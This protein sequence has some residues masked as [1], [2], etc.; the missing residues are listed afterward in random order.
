MSHA[1][2][3][4][5]A[6][7]PQGQRKLIWIA[8]RCVALFNID[9]AVYA[10]DNACPHQGAALANGSLEGTWLRCPAHGLRFNL[11][12]PATGLC[13]THVPISIANDTLTVTL[14]GPPNS[15]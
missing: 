3:I 14:G 12:A 10:I 8:D 6:E 15:A 13:L 9:G 5:V 1:V 2:S 4:P 7:L 11:A